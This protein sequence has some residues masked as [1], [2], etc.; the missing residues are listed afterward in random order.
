MGQQRVDA[1]PGREHAERRNAAGGRVALVD[2]GDIATQ[3]ARHARQGPE[4]EHGSYDSRAMGR[5]FLILHGWRARARGIGRRGWRSRLA[6]RGA[7]VRY[8]C[9]PDADAPRPDR[10]AAALHA[11]LDALAAASGERVVLCHS[12]GGLLWLREAARLTRAARV[13]RVLLVAPPCP[14]G[15]PA[16][17]YAGFFPTG[18]TPAALARAAGDTRVVC[19]TDDPYCPG[20]AAPAG[21]RRW[22][23]RPTSCR[24]GGHLNPEA[25]FGPW[26]EIE[27][28]ALG[29]R[30]TLG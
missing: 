12:L 27:A 4:A 15:A 23:C 29:E 6:G 5:R 10:W 2:G 30:P 17:I 24:A 14:G 21:R 16:E 11:E 26:P 19:A 13:D 7:H 1:R 9:L 8:P 22:A 18:A 3:L 20:E 28:W 25:G